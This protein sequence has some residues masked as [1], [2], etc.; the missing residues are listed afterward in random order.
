MATLRDRLT[1]LLE[2]HRAEAELD[3]ELRF[4]LE[5]ETEKNHAAGMSE[6]EARATALR[7]FGNLEGTKQSCREERRS[8]GLETLLQDLRYGLRTLRR[9]PAYTC[10]AVVTLALGI[11]VN[12]AVFSAVHGV[13]LKPLPY[14]DSEE[15]VV[16]RQKAPE[17]G[18]EDS[19]FSPPEISDLRAMSHTLED[20]VEYHRM[21][22]NLLGRGEPMRVQTGVVSHQFFDLLGLEPLIGRSF[23][24]DDDLPH[25]EPVLLL[26]YDFWQ[27]RFGGDPSVLG[28]LFVMNDRSHAVIGVLP[29]IPQHPDS[30]DVY[31]PVAACPFRSAPTTAENRRARGYYVFGRLRQ[32]VHRLR[33]A[34]ELE[35]LGARMASAHPEDYPAGKPLTITA[36]PLKE[37][38]VREARP[39][40]LLLLA[41]TALVLLIACA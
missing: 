36:T 35:V 3:E 26:S 8:H 12:A 32:G 27:Q 6:A 41:T 4:H 33:A 2:R 19:G 34:E 11:G 23:E 29:P 14:A 10:A 28:E 9:R 40:L 30:N 24:A 39:T 20:L 16:L 17:L 31:M 21:W 25:S 37:V 5:M 22:F 13:L 7:R 1:A 18:I 38:L 15:L